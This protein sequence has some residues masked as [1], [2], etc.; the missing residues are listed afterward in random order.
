MFTR[1]ACVKSAVRGGGICAAGG[2]TWC[3]SML[4]VV[5]EFPTCLTDGVVST[6]DLRFGVWPAYWWLRFGGGEG[7]GFLFRSVQFWCLLSAV[8]WSAAQ[9]GVKGDV[10]VVDADANGL[11]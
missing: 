3:C 10:V 6:A 9:V 4:W 5:M 11:L 8:W 2:G 7:S 1:L